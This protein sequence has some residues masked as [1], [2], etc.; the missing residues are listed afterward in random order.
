[1][2]VEDPTQGYN[3]AI[4]GMA[5]SSSDSDT[6]LRSSANRQ[7]RAR[8]TRSNSQRR[9]RVQ[10]DAD[11]SEKIDTLAST[12][13]DTSRNLHNVDRMLGQYREHTE[14]Q[15]EAMATLR[16]NL[17]ESI[18]QL[19]SQRLRRN[20]GARSASLST[21]HTSDLDG[22]SASEGHHYCPT[23]P[24]RDYGM[25]GG[26][27]RRRSRSATVR[28]MD[29]TDPS[30]NI[31]T[32]HQSLRDLRSEQLRLGDD[33]EREIVRRNRS[34]LETKK[35]LESLAD[36][37]KISQREETVSERV[38]RRLQEI[39]K[40]MRAGRQQAERR[41]EQ[42]GS[43]S[44]QL[45]EA[46]RKREEKATGTEDVTKSKLLRSECEKNKIEQELERTRR[47]LEQSEGSRDTL[48]QQ[49]DDLRTQLLTMEQDR[50]D[51]RQQFSQ[52][53]SRQRSRRE[54]EEED[55]NL[56]MV[57]E[58]SE[59]EKQE[60][61]KQIQDLR[62][63]LTQNAVMAEVDE[64][65]RVIERK[66]REKSQL[67]VHVE[68]LSSD[69][70]KREKQ[71]LRM[72]EQLKEIQNRYEECEA[73]RSRMALQVQELVGQ[74]KESG[75]QADA[76]LRQ[77][78]QVEM[79]KDEMERKKEDLKARAQ[80]SIRQWKLKCKKLEQHLENERRAA[81]LEAEKSGQMLK[82]KESIQGQF[83]TA[84]QQLDNL[85]KELG[86]VLSRL[87][88]KE[89]ELRRKDVEFSE[90]QSQQ[91]D[92]EREIREAREVARQLESEVEKQNLL[93]MQV[94]EENQNLERE[95][96][97][98]RRKRERDQEKMLDLQGAVK[99]LS[100]I[101]AD[102]TN[103]LAEEERARKEL[104]RNLS[105]LQ[106][107]QDRAREEL[108]SAG[109]QL[110]LERDVHQCELAG[111]RAEMQD[112][113]AKHETR[114]QEAIQLF[115]KE[116][117]E[118]ESRIRN[119]QADKAV[120]K[121]LVKAHRQQLE[122]MKIECDKLTEELT[123]SEE[124]YATL[125]RKYQLLKQ[126]LEEKSKL[127]T[128]GDDRVRRMDETILELREQINCLE[129][130]Q[131]SIL[132]TIGIEIDS[133]CKGFS[134]DS[135][136][137]FKAISLTPGL[138]KD[139]HRWLAEMKTKLRWLCEELKER[140]GQ[141]GK[142]RRHLQQG[143][144]QL[145]GL[146]RDR[147][148]EQQ[149]LVAQIAKQ[150]QLLEEIHRDRRD[151]LEKT[152]RKDEE[153]RILHDRI[154]DLEMSTRLALDHL[155]SVPEKLSLLEDFK[156]LE[157]SQRQRE[158]IEHRYVKYKEIVGDLQHQLEESK[159][160]IQEYRDEKVDA[161]S[162]GIRLA[163]LSSSVRGQNSFLSSSLLTD[164]SSPHKRLASPDFD[165]SNEQDDSLP[166]VQNHI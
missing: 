143:R 117:E 85:R 114:S 88:Q 100:A 124:V 155:E 4:P 37:V 12:L 64:L 113:K 136:E 135:D 118:L 91:M 43:V 107:Q 21:L 52:V 6:Y 16:E 151:L 111:L 150:E 59:R 108:A 56:R 5:Q 67:S 65:K 104:K 14:D 15:A 165:N 8:A 1:M 158:M 22:G 11:I 154:L 162:R 115:R 92:L 61:E 141:A 130:E 66:D 109:Q 89:E 159:R 31:H 110:K 125:R 50:L 18:N 131:E 93:Q 33:I 74:L 48:L 20:S 137:K 122:K 73:D 72:L 101:R 87:A 112:L 145:K 126:E 34:E 160:R 40:E 98:L 10:G 99:E 44:L 76:Y 70:G 142:L 119:L 133:A 156:D 103:R 84:S 106:A 2:S 69:L 55:R 46:L 146:R 7:A 121:S 47:Q 30:G 153:M 79:L 90:T 128:S 13:Q 71:Q 23:S 19:R 83:Q 164:S 95:L 94:K 120:D 140:E 25:S 41:P 105:E 152:R 149:L 123:Q 17:E 116:R 3:R 36:H 53:A 68:A 96:D 51:L 9:N 54:E 138:Q 163:T 39:E 29:E 35:T 28:F 58:R 157:E 80:V 148:S 26:A 49:I 139:P 27:E 62:L 144:E 127:V 132:Q 45:Q 63:Q 32:M 97:A 134:R 166:K 78:K 129:T 60:L 102:L 24:L 77:A 86:D 82:D 57:T 42:R 38:E 161:A 75:K 81:G 147:A